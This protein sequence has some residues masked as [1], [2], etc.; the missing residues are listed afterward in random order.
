MILF[1]STVRDLQRHPWQ[2]TL[3]IVGIA[4]GVAVVLA[5]DLTNFSADRA[6]QWSQRA[7]AQDITHQII[8]GPS[9][10]PERLYVQLRKDL[11]IRSAIPIVS[12][13]ILRNRPL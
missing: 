12:G 8:A 11:G 3:S 5:V 1:R 4:L 9:G 2:A 6:M 7:L 13:P 10:V